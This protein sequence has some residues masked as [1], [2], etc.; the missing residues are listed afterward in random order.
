MVTTQHLVQKELEKNPFLIDMFQQELV[1]ISAVAEKIHP[2]IQRELRKEVKLSAV[3]MAI[4]RYASTINKKQVFQWKFPPSLEIATKSQIY[5]VAI[6]KTPEIVKILRV[7]DSKIKRNKG[8]ILSSIEGSYEILI[9]TNQH[10]KKIIKEALRGQKIT[11]ELDNLA[12]VTV[13]WEKLTKDI[14]GI[15]YRITRSLAFKGISI[16][17][18]HTIGAEMMIFFKED[19]FM[20]A[21][22]AIGNLLQNKTEL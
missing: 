14:P 20:E 17:S 13:N 9:F 6:E 4:R 5:E 22:Q 19:V 7:I 2:I 18:F 12:Y 15:Y 3:S 8:D 21:Y 1:N 10:N 16:Q 11:S